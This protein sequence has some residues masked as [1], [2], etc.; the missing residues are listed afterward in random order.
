MY[1]EFSMQ[2]ACTPD[3][4]KEACTFPQKTNVSVGKQMLSTNRVYI[5]F[6]RG[7]VQQFIFRLLE[8]CKFL[9]N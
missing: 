7:P 8:V 5:Q 3:D 2:I 1:R 6:S 4:L 9:Q